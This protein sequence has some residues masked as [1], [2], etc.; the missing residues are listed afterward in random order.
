MTKFVCKASRDNFYEVSLV[1]FQ[2]AVC[3]SPSAIY[4]Q[5]Y[6]SRYPDTEASSLA[7]LRTN[8]DQTRA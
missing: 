7:I 2:L 5:V 3:P 8:Q 4:L 6:G 1:F